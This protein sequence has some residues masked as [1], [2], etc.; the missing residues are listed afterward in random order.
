LKATEGK[1]IFCDGGSEIVNQLLKDK[2]LDEIILSVIP[3]LLGDG[4]RLF[5]DFRPEQRVELQST[6]HFDTGLVQ[7]HYLMK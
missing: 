3:I 5:K 4:V 6:K 1:N 2:L 7:L